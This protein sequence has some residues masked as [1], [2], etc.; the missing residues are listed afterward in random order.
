MD[1]ERQQKMKT[2][3]RRGWRREGARDRDEKAAEDGGGKA[4]KMKT[5]RRR[6]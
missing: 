5:E 2:G 3:K 4:K 1:A 6:G